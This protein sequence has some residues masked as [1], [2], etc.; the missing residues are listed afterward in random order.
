MQL[1]GRQLG[2]PMGWDRRKKLVHLRIA[3]G[4]TRRGHDVRPDEIADRL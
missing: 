3:D 1:P 4:R 2:T